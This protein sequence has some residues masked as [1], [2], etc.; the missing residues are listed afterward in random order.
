MKSLSSCLPD[1][2][3]APFLD[4]LTPWVWWNSTASAW[5]R[6]FMQCC[7]YKKVFFISFFFFHFLFFLWGERRWRVGCSWSIKLK[8]LHPTPSHQTQ[9]MESSKSIWLPTLLS[10]NPIYLTALSSIRPVSLRAYFFSK[11]W[12]FLFQ[13]GSMSTS[14]YCP[15]NI[16]S[17]NIYLTKILYENAK[18]AVNLT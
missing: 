6:S 11:I 10:T 14:M 4:P 18:K 16:T 17:S 8:A 13:T 3:A 9:G 12:C 5:K 7:W 15:E 1:S 2:L